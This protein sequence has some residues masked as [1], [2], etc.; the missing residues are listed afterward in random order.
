MCLNHDNA[1]LSSCPK[2]LGE[3]RCLLAEQAK[4]RNVEIRR[5]GLESG[6]NASEQI[7]QQL[8]LGHS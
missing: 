7:I 8:R 1:T 4:R 6:L 5:A 3:G 2:H